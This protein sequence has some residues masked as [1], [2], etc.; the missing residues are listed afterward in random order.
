MRRVDTFCHQTTQHHSRTITC[1]L[2]RNSFRVFVSW[3]GICRINFSHLEP[4][5]SA[6]FTRKLDYMQIVKS[7]KWI[8][9]PKHWWTKGNIL[10]LWCDLFGLWYIQIVTFLKINMWKSRFGLLLWAHL[11]LLQDTVWKSLSSDNL[12]LPLLLHAQETRHS[13][14]FRGHKWSANF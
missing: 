11:G 12:A 13:G 8:P 1:G 10:S 3:Q 4:F 2:P 6:A 7:T 14:L 5:L 9:V